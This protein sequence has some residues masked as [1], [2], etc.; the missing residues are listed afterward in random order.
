LTA[1]RDPL[2]R[3]NACVN[4]AAAFAAAWRQLD[5]HVLVV[6]AGERAP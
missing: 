4:P 3:P 2:A 6:L 1:V 5:A